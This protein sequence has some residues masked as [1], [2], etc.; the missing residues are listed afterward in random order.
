MSDQYFSI[1]TANSW[2]ELHSLF[3]QIYD[4]KWAFRGQR[5]AGWP[6]L[7]SVSRLAGKFP[8][9]VAE[10]VAIWTF[11]RRTHHYLESNLLPSTELE[12]LALM[13]HHGAPTRLL[14]WTRSPYV[15]TFF[16]LQHKPDSPCCA[17]WAINIGQ[18]YTHAVEQIRTIS[19]ELSR[20]KV[21]ESIIDDAVF[22]SAVLSNSKKFVVPLEPSKMNQRL[23]VQRG[24]FLAPGDVCFSIEDNILAMAAAESKKMISKIEIPSSIRS[25][26]LSEL[27]RM[28]ITSASLF[29]GLDGF[30]AYIPEILAANEPDSQTIDNIRQ[31]KYTTHLRFS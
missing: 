29:P 7:P 26:V 17:V 2:S 19:D 18:C 24:L 22:S 11:K 30:A 6:L 9:D 8:I 27:I 15:A 14:D 13:Q 12:W 10:K 28:N 31:G 21:H 1:R 23:S 16:A 4:H 3:H 20:L 5:E 25:E